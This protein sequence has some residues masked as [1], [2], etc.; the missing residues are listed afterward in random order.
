MQRFLAALIFV[1]LAGCA[2]S[3]RQL[4][5]DVHPCAG[6]VHLALANV[7]VVDGAGHALPGTELAGTPRAMLR[8]GNTQ[9][10]L[11]EF[12]PGCGGGLRVHVPLPATKSETPI[13]ILRGKL[14]DGTPVTGSQPITASDYR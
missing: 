11:G 1:G 5:F 9:T 7:Q 14:A 3:G 10:E 4:A 2:T 6:E 13:I 12:V 8:D